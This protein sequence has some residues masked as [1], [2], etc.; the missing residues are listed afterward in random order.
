MDGEDGRITGYR[1]RRGK[2]YHS[3][4]GE[5][6]KDGRVRTGK[7]ERMADYGQGRGERQNW[8]KE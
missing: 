4:D 6:G 3:E 2:G 1:W 7:R 8:R 5:N